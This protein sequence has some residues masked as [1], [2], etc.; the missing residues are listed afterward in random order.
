M[1]RTF[2]IWSTVAPVLALTAAVWTLT[3][4]VGNEIPSSFFFNSDT[5]FLTSL[6]RDLMHD[7][8]PLSGWKFPPSPYF[9]PD[10]PVWFLLNLLFGPDPGVVNA[11]NLFAQVGLIAAAAAMMT[12]SVAPVWTMAAITLAAAFGWDQRIFISLFQPAHHTGNVINSLFA[13]AVMLRFLEMHPE[14]TDRRPFFAYALFSVFLCVATASDRLFVVTF[15]IPAALAL[16]VALSVQRPVRIGPDLRSCF[17]FFLILGVFPALGMVLVTA[18]DTRGFFRVPHFSPSL[19]ILKFILDPTK[20][21]VLAEKFFSALPPVFFFGAVTFLLFLGWQGFQRRRL[22]R[23]AAGIFL[24][25]WGFLASLCTIGAGVTLGSSLGE[26]DL[27]YTRRYFVAAFVFLPTAGLSLLWEGSRAR[28]GV[29]L[30]IVLSSLFAVAGIAIAAARPPAHPVVSPLAECLDAMRSDLPT[31]YGI[32]DYWNSRIA[33]IAS[34]SG[35]RVNAVE[36]STLE[37]HYWIGNFNWYYGAS[38]HPAYSFVIMTALD[39]PSVERLWGKPGRRTT[40]GSQ[41]IWIYPDERSP[42]RSHLS[43]ATLDQL[44]LRLAQGRDVKIEGVGPR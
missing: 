27:Q 32:G 39:A 30:R 28:I 33:T 18:A 9:F 31:R 42:L 1:N 19:D 10:M 8:F 26:T 14:G 44:W 29:F 41:E 6:Y 25:V 4:A 11:A 35:V 36:P 2:R 43:A 23:N 3:T 12:R 16:I 20:T 7:G 38:G 21:T 22:P 24:P 5:L 17:P 34:K 37:P 13:S 15:V 40:C